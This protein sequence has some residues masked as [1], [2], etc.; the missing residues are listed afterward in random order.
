MG[1]VHNVQMRLKCYRHCNANLSFLNSSPLV[2][3]FL[4]SIVPQ[5][6]N[7]LERYSIHISINQYGLKIEMASSVEHPKC[8]PYIPGTFNYDFNKWKRPSLRDSGRILPT[9]NIPLPRG[10]S[11]PTETYQSSAPQ[12]LSSAPNLRIIGF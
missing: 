10:S 7:K 3:C 8:A 1:N 11:A 5:E 9:R 4:R 12:P 2:C 6:E